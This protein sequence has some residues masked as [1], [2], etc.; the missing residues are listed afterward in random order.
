MAGRCGA[1]H[2][3]RTHGSVHM[4]TVSSVHKLEQPP[5]HTHT[6]THTHALAAIGDHRH[7]CWETETDLS[8]PPL[9]SRAAL[10]GAALGG[11]TVTWHAPILG[12]TSIQNILGCFW[13]W[14]QRWLVCSKAVQAAEERV[15][16][17]RIRCRATWCETPTQSEA[18]PCDTRG[19]HSRR[20]EIYLNISN[21]RCW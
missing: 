14:R 11:A 13:R 8:P 15:L 17:C 16:L 9:P 20:L 19:M 12:R 21:L 5:P 6:H 4:V 3:S 18:R 2:G 10:L 1:R 7:T